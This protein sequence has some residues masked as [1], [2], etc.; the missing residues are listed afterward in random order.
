M[1]PTLASVERAARATDAEHLAARDT[2][3]CPICGAEPAAECKYGALAGEPTGSRCHPGKVHMRRLRLYLAATGRELDPAPPE[4]PGEPIVP[5]MHATIGLAA[6]IGGCEVRPTAHEAR[7]HAR[8]IARRDGL[9]D[10]DMQRLVLVAEAL[11]T[12]VEDL[13][14]SPT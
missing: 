9:D 6:W 1:Q 4:R 3:A 10:F 7:V 12:L 11:T 14:C 13:E 2:T 5:L 8:A